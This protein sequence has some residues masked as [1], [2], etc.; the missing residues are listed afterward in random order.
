MPKN[1][2]RIELERGTIRVLWREMAD[3][4]EDIPYMTLYNRIHRE[5]NIETIRRAYEV[6]G[7][8][9]AKK[10]RRQSEIRRI[11]ENAKQ[12]AVA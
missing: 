5:S 8:I 12:E 2:T 7:R 4:G 3:A 1:E 9:A 11:I 10:Q 6:S